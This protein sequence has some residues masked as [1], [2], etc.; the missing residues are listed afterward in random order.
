MG[1]T[2]AIGTNPWNRWGSW[3]WKNVTVDLFLKEFTTKGKVSIFCPLHHPVVLSINKIGAT[4]YDVISK[5]FYLIH[6][7]RTRHFSWSAK[8][9]LTDWMRTLSLVSCALYLR[10]KHMCPLGCSM[11]FLPTCRVTRSCCS[12]CA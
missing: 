7:Y 12:S 4:S 3:W 6:R 11:L 1:M 9:V 8:I 2:Q 10:V 5:K